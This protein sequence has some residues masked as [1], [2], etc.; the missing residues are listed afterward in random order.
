[1]ISVLLQTLE[2][3][4]TNPWQRENCYRAASSR[5]GDS[6]VAG[7]GRGSPQ[8]VNLGGDP[9]AAGGPNQT[10][11]H[12]LNGKHDLVSLTENSAGT[13]PLQG[14]QVGRKPKTDSELLMDYFD[15]SG[16]I[17]PQKEIT[18]NADKEFPGPG[19]KNSNN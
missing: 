8:R 12:V 10:P 18:A 2:Y 16:S 7:P 1:M 4:I 6:S 15:F 14:N 17:F 11:I 3:Y 19:N 9:P 5:W 13:R